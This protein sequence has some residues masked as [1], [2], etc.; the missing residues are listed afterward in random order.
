MAPHFDDPNVRYDEGWTY[1]SPDDPPVTP[2]QKRKQMKNVIK[3]ALA[4]FS[5]LG[6]I[7]YLQA[8][9]AKM[10]GNAA[11]ATVATKTTALNTAVTALVTANTNYEASKATTD[12]LMTVRDN[13]VI[14]AENAVQDLATAS[15]GVTKDPATLQSGGWEVVGGHAAPVGPMAAPANFHATGGDNAGEVD[16]MCDPQHGVQT[17]QA[18]YATAP[19]GPFTSFYTGKKSSCAATGL[20][21]GT[22]YW[23]H[24]R[25]VG[26]AGPGPWAGPISKRAT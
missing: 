7:A 23:F 4:H 14:T 2:A 12:Q 24:M 11:F 22:L 18:E 13:A 15:E 9:Y 19:D 8:I 10:N 5:I 16:L 20:V 6:L 17:H 1:D 26:A 3:L 25:A 21:S